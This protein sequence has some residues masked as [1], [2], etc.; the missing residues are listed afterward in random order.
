M[1]D[2][3]VEKRVF[4]KNQPAERPSGEDEVDLEEA[5]PVTPFQIIRRGQDTVDKDERLTFA[6]FSPQV[7]PADA[8]EEVEVEIETVPKEESAPEPASSPESTSTQTT[9]SQTPEET[10]KE[11]ATSD[12]GSPNPSE[13]SKQSSS[14]PPKT[15]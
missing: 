8:Q 12:D 6:D 15:G 3:A 14:T 10:V 1:P 9:Q 7:L 11:S 2:E 4:S 5:V 13:S